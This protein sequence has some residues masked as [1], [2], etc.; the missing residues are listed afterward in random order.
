VSSRKIT[1]IDLFAGIG[2][3]RIAFERTGCECVW[4]CDWDSDAQDVYEANFGECPAGD[5]TEIPSSRIPDHDI[6]VAGFPCPSFSI[7]GARKGLSDQNGSLFF[8]IERILKDKKTPSFLLENVRDL[9]NHDHGKTLDTILNH[10]QNIP[11]FVY[12]RVLN[13]LNFGLPQKRERI[14]IVGFRN[15]YEFEFPDGSKIRKDLKEILEDDKKV[16]ERYWASEK[17]RKNRA[18]VVKGKKIFY[19]SIWHENKGG[20]IGVHPYSCALRANASYNYLLV[21]GVRRLTPKEML[22]LQGFPEDFKI[23]GSYAAI[24]KL[25][26][27]SVPIPM[28]QAVAERMLQAME[29]GR[30]IPAMRQ[31][32][33]LEAF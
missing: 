3:C 27:N 25:I 5:I 7:I 12:C 16:P 2:G 29:L 23:F 21:N 32:R 8:Q 11:Y 26:G 15:N 10:L 9:K 33:I 30:T 4:S 14:I 20:D 19:P 17:I 22:R 24:R 28:I 18:R 6:L 1:F 13:A 31:A